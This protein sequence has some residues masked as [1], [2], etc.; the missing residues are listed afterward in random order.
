[1]PEGRNK[2]LRPLVS[3][4][5]TGDG[6]HG[7]QASRVIILE[8]GAVQLEAVAVGGDAF[9]FEE[10]LEPVAQLQFAGSP[11][12]NRCSS[13]QNNRLAFLSRGL[14]AERRSTVS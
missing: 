9:R 2:L 12:S 1:M 3:C 10:S 14:G 13:I 5:E 7:D 4:G 6:V 11:T 8:L